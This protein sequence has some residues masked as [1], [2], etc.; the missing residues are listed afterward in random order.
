MN[1]C[2]SFFIAFALLL[3]SLH[4]QT[5]HDASE[6]NT[7]VATQL[8]IF[9][10]LYKTLDLYY[11]DTLNAQK[12]IEN[13]MTYM[14]YQLDPFTEYMNEDAKQSLKQ[15]TTGKYAGIGALIALRPSEMR[16]VIAEPYAGMPAAEAGLQIGD[17]LMAIDGRDL[18]VAKKGNERDYSDSV[19]SCLRGEPGTSF[20][21]TVKR[22]GVKNNF[23]VTLT[24]RAITLP[25]VGL[26]KLFDK[27]VGYIALNTFSEQTANEVERALLDLK[28]QGAI[29]LV[30]DLRDNGGGLVQPAIK[31]ANFFLPKDKL[32]LSLRGRLV[33]NNRQYLTQHAPIDTEMPLVVLVNEH[34][35]SSAEILAGALQDYDRAL[36]LGRRTYGKG[37]VQ[38]PFDLPN[39]ALVKLTSAKYY[40]PSGR[41]LQAYS[42]ENGEAKHKPD[43]LAKLF[44]TAAGRPVYDGGGITPDVELKADT[45]PEFVA[46]LS[47]SEHTDN[48]VAHYR[49]QHPFVAPAGTFLL[50]DADYK[51]Y[52]DFMKKHKFS[53]ENGLQTA[54]DYLRERAAEK[55]YDDIAGAEFDALSARLKPNLEH[56]FAYWENQVRRSLTLKLMQSYYYAKGFTEAGLKTDTDFN[57]ALRF[58]TDL[59]AYKR[60][61]A[62]P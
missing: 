12:N 14:L 43:S 27:G 40:T 25:S 59:S 5:L 34:T 17:V 57:E 7:Q 8:D 47:T 50:T 9:N 58:L 37:V 48:F 1:K 26:T 15:F 2:M 18:G 19:S 20:T 35:A 56:D 42:Y 44:H 32:L 55:G 53:Y 54:V 30:L 22:F 11:V 28:R 4:A 10:A 13:A 24:R 31:I 3:S 33:Q 6:H 16:C 61:L 46:Y 51:A 38:T 41:S 60:L 49:Q 29:S 36:I 21:L 52:V 39:N 62:T 45:I 23:E